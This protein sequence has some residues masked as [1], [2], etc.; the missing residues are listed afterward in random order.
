MIR[1]L[2]L[3][4]MVTG[5]ATVGVSAQA[6]E[7][8]PV[9]VNPGTKTFRDCPLCPEMV[10]VPAGQF[11]MGTPGGAEEYDADTGET[12]TLAVTIAQ[13][14]ALGRT[15]VTY[16]QYAEFIRD[17]DYKPAPG[18][19]IWN[20]RWVVD[21]KADWR[22]PRQP[23]NPKDDHAA[24]CISFADAQAYAAWL[25][26]KT[27]KAYR[28]PS[29][30]EWE[31]AVRAGT[32]APR[33]FGVNSFEGVSISLACEYANVFDVTGQA[34]FAFAVPYA[35]C[36][37]NYDDVALVAAFKPNAFGLYDMIGNVW[38]W[39]GDCYTGS[40]WG[41][42]PDGSTW[43]W[44]GGCEERGLRGGAWSSRPAA[45]RSA[46]RSSAPADYRATDVGFR[47]A[48]DLAPGEVP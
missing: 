43:V 1:W 12:Q 38:E 13:P 31:Y 34:A 45:A 42:P 48:R 6:A 5:F 9:K 14:F 8:D 11:V 22:A 23:R 26:T 46:K 25:S 21:E 7:D 16:K 18:C 27:G 33:F 3:A 24:V 47:I 39:V 41:R 36:K 29:E 32:A 40:Y 35:R 17:A 37:D 19:R 2:A 20:D 44:Q 10:V 15:E 28:L 30:S 4:I